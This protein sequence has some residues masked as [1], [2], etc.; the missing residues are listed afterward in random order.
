MEPYLTTQIITY[1]G[2]KRKLL[3]TIKSIIDD[4]LVKEQRLNLRLG[5]GFSGSGIVSRLFKSYGSELYTNDIA[6]YSYVLNHCY[7]ANIT[8]DVSK[9]LQTL[10][11][12]ANTYA[13]DYANP[14]NRFA[15]PAFISGN[16][17]PKTEKIELGERVYFTYENGKRIDIL[18]NFIETL[19][20]PYK[21]I[22]LG[23]LLVEVSIH[24]NTNGQF[25]A[26]YKGEDQR[27]QYGGKH[28]I[29]L[30]RIAAP[31]VLSMPVSMHLNN[32][33]SISK[34]DTIEWARNIPP[35]DFV[36]YD[37]PYNKHPYSI[38]YFMLNIVAEWNTAIK[39]PETTRGQ[40][41]DW[42]RSAYNSFKHATK[43][44]DTLISITKARYILISYNSG[45]IIPV[46]TMDAIL[47]KYGTVSKIPVEHKTYN[48]LKGISE[49]KRTTQKEAIKEFFWLLQKST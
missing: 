17:A 44:F 29:D 38:Y 18:R 4:I 9:R 37:P 45:G 34:C 42:H 30:Q 1:L 26:Y 8:P 49:Y 16:W 47:G 35:L 32:K 36:Y 31:I 46:D 48:R 20:E 6:D 15:K 19:R 25:S 39:I 41:L 11:T 5:D 22:L 14:N 10:I 3:P 21:T 33:V 27:G 43:E 12:E 13:D 7:L 40:P 23:R 24:N 28:S 2:N